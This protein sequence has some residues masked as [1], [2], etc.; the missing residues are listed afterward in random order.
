MADTKETKKTRI[1]YD[2]EAMTFERSGHVYKVE[3]DTKGYPEII[4]QCILYAYQKKAV[5]AIAGKGG[6]EYT[7]NE[8]HDIMQNVIN[9]LNQGTWNVARPG[10]GVKVDK[11]AAAK[12][13]NVA[14]LRL[15]QKIMPTLLTAEQKAIL[16]E[17]DELEK[18]KYLED[19]PELAEQIEETE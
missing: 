10:G 12:V 3:H 1:T 4:R 17:A 7:D 2:T 19:H 9:A 14:E 18:E 6:K 15:L 13:Y 16:A 5:D 11:E 8:R